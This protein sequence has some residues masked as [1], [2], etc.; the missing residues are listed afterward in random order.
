MVNYPNVPIAPGVPPV[1]RAPGASLPLPPAPLSADSIASIG[2]NPGQPQWG[3]FLGN[4]SVITYDSFLDL[5]FRRD[6]DIPNFPQ[7]GGAFQSY[8]KVFTPFEP[9]IRLTCGGTI[10]RRQAF[11]TAVDSACASL[12]LYNVVTPETVYLNVNPDHYDL[13]RTASEGL[14]LLTVEIW[15]KQIEAGAAPAFTNTRAPSSANAVS[16]GNVQPQ[17]ATAAEQMLVQQNIT[18]ASPEAAGI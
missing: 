12:N 9:R 4:V 3:V 18:N 5:T 2:G 13:K 8:N 7:E 16:G 6:W 1:L 10:A 14:G 11:L 17:S 15:F